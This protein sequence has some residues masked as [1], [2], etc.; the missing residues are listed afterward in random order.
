MS[1]NSKGDV[2]EQCRR[3]GRCLRMSEAGGQVTG[4]GERLQSEVLDVRRFLW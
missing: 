2:A 1:K 4:A 3:M